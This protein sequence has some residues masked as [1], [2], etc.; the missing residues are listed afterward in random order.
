MD[1]VGTCVFLAGSCAL[2][3]AISFGG[4]VYSFRSAATIVL[5]VLSGFF[6]CVM[7]GVAWYHPGVREEDRLYPAHYLKSPILVNIQ[8]QMF[9]VSGVILVSYWLI[10]NVALEARLVLTFATVDDLLY[11]LVLPIRK[12]GLLGAFPRQNFRC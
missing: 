7:V 8:L 10:S 1:W 9:L 5:W 6:L 12:G 4:I 3:L 2:T 11:P